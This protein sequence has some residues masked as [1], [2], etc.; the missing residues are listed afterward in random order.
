MFAGGVPFSPPFPPMTLVAEASVMGWEVY[1]RDLQAQVLSTQEAGLYI[2]IL[3]LQAVATVH[4]RFL[5]H[6]QGRTIHVLTDNSTAMFC[7][8][9]LGREQGCQEAVRLWHFC[10]WNSLTLIRPTDSSKLISRPVV[11]LLILD[12]ELCLNMAIQ[13]SV[14]QVG[15]VPR[16]DLFANPSE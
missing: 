11:Q 5:P 7:A 1:L 15:G 12:Q 10:I 14:L 4:H 2:N 6:V 13:R 8:N 3:E 9:K 16:V